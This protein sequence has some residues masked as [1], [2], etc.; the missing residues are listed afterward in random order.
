M[1]CEPVI[2][3]CVCVYACYGHAQLRDGLTMGCLIG[4]CR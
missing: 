3:V 2:H 1:L 4:I